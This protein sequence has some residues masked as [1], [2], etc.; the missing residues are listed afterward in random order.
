MNTHGFRT[1][2]AGALLLLAVSS[3]AANISLT[4]NDASG[5][6]SFNAKLNWNSTAAPSSGNS[7]DTGVFGMRTP[8]AV[9]NY[10]FANDAT[11]PL[12]LSTAN[13]TAG[14]YSLAYKVNGNSVLTANW[15]F[16]GGYIIHNN[17]STQI[18]TF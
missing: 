7:Y 6:S 14:N 13:N 12:T 3:H 10:T 15:L 16:N 9:A 5:A 18:G 8:T 2:V 1:Q 4:N 17:S 11:V